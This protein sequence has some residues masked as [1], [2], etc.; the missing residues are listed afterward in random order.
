MRY[1]GTYEGNSLRHYRT[2][3]SR[4][5]ISKNPDYKPIGELAKGPK[6]YDS[7]RDDPDWEENDDNGY[8]LSKSANDR[9]WKESF[10][11][12]GEMYKNIGKKAGEGLLNVFT[13]GAYGRSKKLSKLIANK[14]AS[15]SEPAAVPV[16]KPN[17]KSPEQEYNM[18]SAE[19]RRIEGGNTGT[20]SISNGTNALKNG[21]TGAQGAGVGEGVYKRRFNNVA[22][23]PAHVA[24]NA[25]NANEQATRRNNMKAAEQRRIAGSKDQ[26][27]VEAMR[28]NRMRE[29]EQRRIAGGRTSGTGTATTRLKDAVRDVGSNIKNFGDRASDFSMARMK[30]DKSLDESL[31]V[32]GSAKKRQEV[33]DRD[34]ERMGSTAYSQQT[35]KNINS[36]NL[37][38]HAP[39]MLKRAYADIK[40]GY[41]DQAK[42]VKKSVRNTVNAAGDVGS[43]LVKKGKKKVK[44][45]MKRFFG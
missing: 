28:R 10:A 43:S 23:A 40:G 24:L 42:A 19:R 18:R 14:V 36:R 29:A 22:A 25:I 27:A 35:M 38:Y 6:Y 44:S 26:G 37:Q 11:E 45:L 5:G 16:Y 12:T 8:H 41:K 2:K 39:N 1:K 15:K 13:K 33:I 20:R 31:K 30:N 4:N 17:K 7:R 21:I 34:K 32:V 3:G 9:L